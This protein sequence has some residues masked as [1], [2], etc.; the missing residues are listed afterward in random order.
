ML[1]KLKE[2]LAS[3]VDY[4]LAFPSFTVWCKKRK[5]KKKIK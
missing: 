5:V 3:S 2:T 4:I 1:N